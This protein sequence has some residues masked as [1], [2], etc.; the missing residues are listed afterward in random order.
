MQSSP[1]LFERQIELE[2]ESTSLGIVRYAKAQARAD[3]ADTGPGRRLVLA[4]VADTGAA[5]RAF[6]ADADTGRPGKRHA[7][8]KWLKEMDADAC[9]YLTATICVN[10]LTGKKA[11]V[12]GV[13]RSVGSALAQDINYKLLRDTHKGLYRVVQEQLKKSTSAHHAT[14]VMNHTLVKANEKA[15]ADRAAGKPDAKA[16]M[17][18]LAFDAR[19]EV[20][21]GM[22]LIELFIQATGLAELYEY[23]SAA[24]SSLTVLRGTPKIMEWLEK[25][26]DSASM[27]LPVWLPMLVPPQPWTTPTNG[28]YLT[29]IGGRADLVRTRNRAY[30]AE[31]ANADMPEVYRALNLIQGTA[32]KINKAVLEVMQQAWEAGGLIGGLPD[33]ELTALPD[34]PALLAENPEFYREHH[35][36]DFK[37][38]KRSR[39]AVYEQNARSVSQRVAAAQKIDL[40]LKFRDEAAIYFPHNLDFRGRCYPIPSILTPQGDDQA[41]SLLTFAKGARLGADGVFWLSIHLANCFGVDKVSFEDRVA[42]VMANEDAILDSAL[43]P[44][45]GERLWCKADSPYCALAACFEWLGYRLNGEDHVSHLPVALD[46]SCNGLQNFSAM[47]RDEIGGAATNLIAHSKPADIYTEVLTLVAARVRT[48][49]EAGISAALVLDGRLSRKIV[50]TPVMTLPYGVTKSGMRAQVLDAASKEGIKLDWDAAEYL[51]ELLWKCIGEV[52]IAARHAMDWL[53]AASKVASAGDLPISWTTPAGFPVLQ[54]YREDKGKRLQMHVGGRVMDI[55]VAIDGTT[56]DRRRQALGISPNFVHSCDASHMMLTVNVAADNGLDSFAMIH[57]SYG[58]HAAH[59]G[60]IAAALRHAFVQQYEG[61]VLG[62]FR[63]ELVAQ[64][65]INL[66]E[67]I[68]PLPPTGNLDLTAVNDSRYFFA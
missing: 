21:I 52:V 38:W 60:V 36:D 63:D 35:A 48:D 6:V 68:P 5:I 65:P 14:G 50:K 26:H 8:V 40:A 22:K 29:D 23:R 10:A 15:A 17:P 59:T 1:Q 44:L 57:D 7:A 49:A 24:R 20:T 13:A 43:N 30:K 51:A 4:A 32:W 33:R 45:D 34:Q 64:L 9:A 37:A 66:G 46:G 28:G 27:F 42:W 62:A 53:K 56:L 55:T 54:E 39:A 41:K 31:L 11:H 18:I 2:R 19:T 16:E 67:K 25:A 12:T 58:T 61:D 3:E 47:L